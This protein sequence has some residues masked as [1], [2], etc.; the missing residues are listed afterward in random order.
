M[1]VT[2]EERLGWCGHKLRKP[3][4]ADSHQELEKTRKGSSLAPP[5]T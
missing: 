4:N 2:T 1:K 3:R 5:E